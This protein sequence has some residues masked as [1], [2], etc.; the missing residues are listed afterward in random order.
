MHRVRFFS[1][2]ILF[3]DSIKM[4]SKEIFWTA[5]K[6]FK[7][8]AQYNWVENNN[9]QLCWAEDENLLAWRKQ[10]VFYGNLN[11]QQYVDY[12]LRFL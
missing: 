8:T 3:E 4:N 2:E 12:T 7:N 5:A 10:I 1:T 6:Q 9:V 11:E